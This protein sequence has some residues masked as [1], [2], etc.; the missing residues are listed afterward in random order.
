M[1]VAPPLAPTDP[2]DDI[3]FD[4]VAM[5]RDLAATLDRCLIE[6]DRV[7]AEIVASPPPAHQQ[8]LV[9]LNRANKD[10]T[11]ARASLKAFEGIFGI[12]GEPR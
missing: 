9:N 11:I 6:R 8:L 7:K 5:H 2:A 3:M 10:I 1:T 4:V 12:F